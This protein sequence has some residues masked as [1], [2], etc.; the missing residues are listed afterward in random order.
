M[1]SKTYSGGIL[2]I[3]GYL[4]RAEADVSDGL[5]QFRMVGYLSSEVKEAEERVRTAIR[6]SG[7][8]LPPKRVTVNLSPAD[9][10]KEGTCCDLAVAVAVLASHGVVDPQLPGKS[11]FLGELSLDGRIRAV[12]GVLPMVIAMRDAGLRY[13][14]LP[15]ENVCEGLAVEGIGIVKVSDLAAL[16]TVLNHPGELP[17]EPPEKILS[18][19]EEPVYPVDFADV[20]GQR[21]VLRA[22]EIA[23]AGMHNLLYIGPP[24]SGKSMIAR[25]IP[26]ILPEM[27]GEEQLEVSKVYSICG[28]LPPDRAWM[29]TRPFRAPHHTVSAQAMTGGGRRPKPGE[30]SLASRGVLFLDELPEFQKH[31]LEIL[32][33]PLEDH[34]VIVARVHGTFSFP[35]HFMLAAAMNPCPCGY[36]PDR[37]RCSCTIS[38]VRNYLGKISRP[39]LDRIDICVE[40]A[41]VTYQDLRGGAENETSAEIRA[42]VERCRRVQQRRFAE[43]G[44]YFNGE[45]GSREI[46]VYCR[47]GE[48]EHTFLD[49]VYRKLGLSARGCHKILKVARTIADMAG[50]E[51]IRK[52]HLSEAVGYRDLEERYWGGAR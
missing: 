46:A 49:Q 25:R 45:M 4:V 16:V 20:S 15:E 43:S 37:N 2:G 19:E 29:R 33:Q 17:L 28:M 18:A 52:E 21:L 10:R 32:R 40:A 27:S 22:T 41:P 39:L 50:S 44:I 51:E 5:P 11:G 42:R 36:F 14:F 12:H 1:F 3:E 13:C 24:G 30:I 35:A 26:T 23:A 47:L 31:T 48:A 38:Q 34:R 9:I 6:N 7:F 8:R